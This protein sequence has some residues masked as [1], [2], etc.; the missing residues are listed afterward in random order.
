[1]SRKAAPARR[2]STT[3]A[4]CASPVP[5]H[6]GWVWIGRVEGPRAASHGVSSPTSRPHAPTEPRARRR[7]R[8]PRASGPAVGRCGP[9]VDQ[10]ANHPPDQ[11]RRSDGTDSPE[12]EDRGPRGEAAARRLALGRLAELGHQRVRHQSH[13]EEDV[14]RDDHEIVEEAQHGDDVEDEVDGAEGVG[15]HASG[16]RLGVPRRARIPRGDPQRLRVPL[17]APRPS[18]QAGE[19]IGGHDDRRPKVATRQT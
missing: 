6:R 14:E 15:R 12:Q 8:G 16:Q 9:P 13:D 5:A 10:E 17:E 7:G 4:S 11:E 3:W 18:A 1:M 2:R 19:E